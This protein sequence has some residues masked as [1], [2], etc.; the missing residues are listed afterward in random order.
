VQ[1]SRQICDI[2]QAWMEM[3]HVLDRVQITELDRSNY[4][5]H[6]NEQWIW[7]APFVTALPTYSCQAGWVRV[8]ITCQPSTTV[9]RR[10]L[11]SVSLTDR[12]L[13]SADTRICV[14]SRTNTRFGDMF[15]NLPSKKYGTVSRLH[16]NSL[17]GLS[18]AVFK[19]HLKSYSFNAIWDWGA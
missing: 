14:V 13:R 4:W 6:Y 18:F 1:L 3:C 8:P 12:H 7:R 17:H 15:L 11:P 16:S 9:H 2:A 19:Q 5:K 10:R